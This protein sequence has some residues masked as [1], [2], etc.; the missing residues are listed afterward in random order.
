MAGE[1]AG[2][3]PPRFFALALMCSYCRSRLGL[4]PVGIPGVLPGETGSFTVEG[5]G[6]HA[7]R[8]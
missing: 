7:R 5:R 3:K 2:E 1:Q 4:D 6:E 8:E